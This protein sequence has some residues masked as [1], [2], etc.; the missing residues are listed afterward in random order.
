MNSK[1]TRE[2]IERGHQAR[3][4]GRPQEALEHYRAALAGEPDN[5]EAN[6]VYGLMLL[7]L[8]RASEAE[9]PLRKAV[10]LAP[11]HPACRMNLAELLA[12][13]GLLDEAEQHVAGVSAEQPQHWWAWDRLGDLRARQKK[14]ADAARDYARAAELKPNDPSILYKWAR[15][16]FDDG[17]IEDAERILKD[18]IRLA[19]DHE[20]I[21]RL[22]AEILESRADWAGLERR[23]QTWTQ[24]HPKGP[25]GWRWLARAQW[26]TGFLRQAMQNFRQS[27]D[28]GWRD[29]D[30]LAT[31]A[32]LC[33]SALEF[34]SATA[35]L[36]EAEALDPENRPMLSARAVQ[37]M[38]A[39]RYAEAERYCRRSLSADRDDAA[40]YRLLVQLTD[41]RLP[42]EDFAGLKRLAGREDIS[43]SGRIA[44]AFAV[45]ECFDARGE[46]DEAFAAW[47]RANRLSAGNTVKEGIRYDRVA[48]A[49]QTDELIAIFDSLPSPPSPAGVAGPTPIF[50]VGMPRSGT[51]LVESI[52]GA[53]SGVLACGERMSLRW[54]M[55]EFVARARSGPV[56]DIPDSAWNA[57]RE[58]FW[59]EL[60]QTRGA[61]VVTDKNPWNFD[62]LGLI[63]RLFPRARIIH[64][65]RDPVETGLSIFRNTFTKFMPFTNR[66]EDI[67]HYYGEYAR[68]MAYWNRVLGG[69][70]TT[71]QYENLLA[72]FEVEGPAL[73][74][75]C[76]L[77]WEESCREFWK[78]DRLI[79]TMSTMQ[80]RRPLA[81]RTGRA[82]RYAAHVVPLVNALEAAGVD[83]ATGALKPADG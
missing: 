21:L 52:I 19:P 65:R 35:A 8:G 40:T 72:R 13:Q 24:A 70:F 60:P 41:G 46:P 48:Q 29:A 25:Q 43:A 23:A 80:A 77:E 33:L 12:Y 82:E 11:S 83:L 2:D 30:S 20:L 67:G 3:R 9:P 1:A 6:T 26:E 61:A 16:T 76:G 5:A 55:Q 42:E 7:H 54:I 59:R 32:R 38:F 73:L 28:L 58:F 74:T 39:G 14:F 50:I 18:A 79:C 47:G 49:R 69:R 71:V 78:S 27:L 31:F 75:A 57:W 51:T 68:L 53:H 17:R 66:L 34:A 4:A 45:A 81:Q 64:V 56:A 62:A 63:L 15:S 36:D 22:G 44:A 10:E 37:L